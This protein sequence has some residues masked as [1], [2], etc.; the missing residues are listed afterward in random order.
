MTGSRARSRGDVNDIENAHAVIRVDVNSV[1]TRD[2]QRDAHLRS[3]DFFNAEK[4][5]YITFE[6][7]SI[8]KV[9]GS[10]YKIRGGKLTI[11]DVTKE[12]EVD[13]TFEG[14]QK[15]PWGGN[16]RFG[17]SVEGK[18]NRYDFG[19]RWNMPLEG[20]GVLVGDVVKFNVSI[21]AMEK[22]NN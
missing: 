13:G 8:K 19:L 7:T 5:P 9:S 20:G 16:Q 10:E 3:D 22:K 1:S 6:T 17:F 11:R 4:Y 18:I 15:D 12:I 2:K 21:E 14:I